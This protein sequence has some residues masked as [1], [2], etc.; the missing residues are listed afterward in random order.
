MEELKNQIEG[1]F[2]LKKNTM[3]LNKVLTYAHRLVRGRKADLSEE[4]SE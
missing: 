3:I 4:S 2:Y 1:L